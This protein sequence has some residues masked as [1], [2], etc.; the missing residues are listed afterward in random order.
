MTSCQTTKRARRAPTASCSAG[1][2]QIVEQPPRL[3]LHQLAAAYTEALGSPDI[4][5]AR[6]G[7]ELLWRQ[8]EQALAE[9]A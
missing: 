1:T 7:L 8:L 5:V 6:I 2:F 3:K 4:R 9:E